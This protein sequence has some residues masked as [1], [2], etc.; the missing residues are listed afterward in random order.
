MVEV[1]V[2]M[3]CDDNDIVTMGRYGFLLVPGSLKL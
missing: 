2:N 3:M 1:V